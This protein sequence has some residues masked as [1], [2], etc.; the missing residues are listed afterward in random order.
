MAEAQARTL[1]DLLASY[2]ASSAGRG[3]E[4]SPEVL[5][6][7]D[8]FSAVSRR[9]PVW[10]LYERARSLGLAVQVSAQSWQGLAAGEDVQVPDRGVRRRRHLAAAHA[11][12]RAVVALAANRKV[13]DAARRLLGARCGAI[14]AR[15]RS[16]APRCS[17]RTSPAR[18]T[19]AGPVRLQ[20]RVTFIQVKRLV[21]APAHCRRRSRAAAGGWAV[22][23]AAP[24]RPRRSRP[25][26]GPGRCRPLLDAA[27]RVR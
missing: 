21:A 7:V 19:S 25:R 3:G 5:L 16:G 22:T 27:F 13:I 6:A 12:P 24:G 8:E 15:H 17:T 14:T 2:V 26:P 18:S 20:G 23:A 9:L 4:D 11:A 1:V 10:Q